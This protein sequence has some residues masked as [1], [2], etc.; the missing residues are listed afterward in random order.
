MKKQ[1]LKIK[2][3]IPIEKTTFTFTNLKKWKCCISERDIETKKLVVIVEPCNPDYNVEFDSFIDNVLE[4][5]NKI[6]SEFC[7]IAEEI[8]HY[9]KTNLT[10]KYECFKFKVKLVF[11]EKDN[12]EVEVEA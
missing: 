4:L 11:N 12:V 1:A 2:T 5:Y 9:I 7:T 8:V 6:T 3:G 10:R